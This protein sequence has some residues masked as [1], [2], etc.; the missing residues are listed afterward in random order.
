MAR[1]DYDSPAELFPS[2]RNLRTTRVTYRRFASAADAIRYAVEML[3]A[4]AFL[5]TYL[6]VDEQRFDSGAIR[7]LYDAPE[8]PFARQADEAVK[9]AS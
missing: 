7:R 3:P 6:E 8:Y 5:G 4:T 9:Q 1:F 2:R